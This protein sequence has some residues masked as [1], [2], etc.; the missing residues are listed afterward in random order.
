MR[1][2][3][4]RDQIWTKFWP[5]QIFPS[6]NI[7]FSKQKT[8][9]KVSLTIIGNIQCGVWEKLVKMTVLGPKWQFL[10]LFARKRGNWDFFIEKR[11]MPLS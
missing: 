5:I 3:K 11:K 4:H 6:I 7:N 9:N 2:F 8:P 1:G 10:E